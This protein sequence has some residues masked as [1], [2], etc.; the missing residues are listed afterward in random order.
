MATPLNDFGHV[1]N[2][3]HNSAVIHH[4]HVSNVPRISY[5]LGALETC[6]SFAC[7]GA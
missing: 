4:G 7:P 5:R 2:V 3:P 6:A 1:R